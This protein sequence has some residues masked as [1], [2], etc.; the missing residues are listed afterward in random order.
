MRLIP[1]S[2]YSRAG[3][4]RIGSSGSLRV[5][6]PLILGILAVVSL[7]SHL[8]AAQ[9]AATDGGFP[10][11]AAEA[12]RVI[13]SH[14][15]VATLARSSIDTT[16]LTVRELRTGKELLRKS[17]QAADLIAFNG[18]YVVRGV[19]DA[20]SVIEVE[21][22]AERVVF[23]AADE[24]SVG[25][26]CVTDSLLRA[27]VR[28]SDD[29]M[30]LTANLDPGVGQTTAVIPELRTSEPIELLCA[31]DSVLV[32]ARGAAHALF[33]RDGA[34][35]EDVDLDGRSPLAL[36][37]SNLYAVTTSSSVSRFRFAAS[38]GWE[39]FYQDPR[40][41]V[42]G[43]AVADSDGQ[44]TI[45]QILGS[46]AAEFVRLS[47][48]PFQTR[49]S[50]SRNLLW[51]DS[52][53][54]SLSDD[55]VVSVGRRDSRSWVFV[56]DLNSL[57]SPGLPGPITEVVTG[58]PGK[59]A[60]AWLNSQLGSPFRTRDGSE[61]RLIDSYEDAEHTGWTY[62]AALAA[63]ALTAY[64]QIDLARQLLNGLAHLQNDDGSWEFAY[65]LD[66]AEP[67]R[68][69][70]YVGSIAWVVMAA[71]FFQWET[72]DA[73]FDSMA[74]RALRFIETFIVKDPASAL[75]GAVTMGP[76]NPKIVSTE[77][78]VDALSAFWWHG[79]LSGRTADI[80][81][82]DRLRDFVWQR[83]GNGDQSAGF[84]FKVGATDSS[85]YL[86][87]QTWT[88]LALGVADSPEP[89]LAS[90]LARAAEKLRV[91]HGH[92][93]SITDVVGFKD[94]ES[95]SPVKV[96]TEG[97]EGMVAAL[98]SIGEIDA[99]RPFHEQTAR[100]QTASG[101]IPYATDSPDGWSTQASVAGT[102]W[103]LLNNLWPPRN[104]FVPDPSLWLKAFGD[105]PAMVR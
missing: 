42:V 78:S 5:R 77:N 1:L 51:T 31:H 14:D 103:F 80:D 76:A 88:S 49:R 28:R 36:T 53:A 91:E 62:D 81:T 75:A 17:A 15:R 18:R 85:L 12:Q 66:Q 37:N 55:V 6:G 35:A 47:G 98:L 45:V 10:L 56:D 94:A 20:V 19:R 26:V 21:S 83:L 23:Q 92:R 73:T 71:N 41:R 25:A 74:D 48:D 33:W 79:R 22:Q 100:L 101:G 96:W 86:D 9:N 72:G 69:P 105:R 7:C 64:G 3:N 13:V 27:V 4:G 102:A 24:G 68:G 97:T 70:R 32:H 11:L 46:G 60:L 40:A 43:I 39:D 104:P 93:D 99:A 52:S 61:G 87:A 8:A 65:D 38:S 90:A 29:A 54:W 30:L 44:A 84:F 58:D 63:V 50:G 89:R 95:A 16:S 67:I 59:R 57:A 2:A 82:A 34:N